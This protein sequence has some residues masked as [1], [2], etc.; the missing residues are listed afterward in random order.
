MS[1]YSH[2][3]AIASSDGVLS[4]GKIVTG[5]ASV[6]SSAAAGLVSSTGAIRSLIT[7]AASVAGA[8][9]SA[10]TAS[11]ASASA[12]KVSTGGA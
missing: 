7:S 6:A 10:A 12:A 4:D 2:E 1:L 11:A 5:E 3:M 8:S 9:G